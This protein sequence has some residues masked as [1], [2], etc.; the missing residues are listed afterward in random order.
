MPLPNSVYR[1]ALHFAETRLQKPNLRRFD[2]Q[3]EGK[4]VLRNFDP[5][6]AGFKTAIQKSFG[7]IPVNDGIL[8]IEFVHRTENP[9]IQA[10]EIEEIK[11]STTERRGRGR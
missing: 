1:I 9:G 2:V 7:E 4:E 3:F 5:A 8:D 10:I 6:G 11:L